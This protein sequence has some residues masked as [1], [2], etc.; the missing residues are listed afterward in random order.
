M[1]EPMIASYPWREPKRFVPQLGNTLA[2]FAKIGKEDWETYIRKDPMEFGM[3][4]IKCEDGKEPF[5][6]QHIQDSATLKT[7]H[8][9]WP[10]PV[11][12]RLRRLSNTWGKTS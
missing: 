7:Y 12:G 8:E 3:R 6:R 10:E 11:K 4:F 9:P 5:Y 1:T 2:H